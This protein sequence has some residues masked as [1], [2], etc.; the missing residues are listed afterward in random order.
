MI[1]KVLL[2]VILALSITGYAQIFT[3]GDISFKVN[4]S[5]PSTVQVWE[6][7]DA[8]GDLVIPRSISFKGVSY[9]VTS[10]GRSAFCGNKLIS[11]IIPASITSIEF[12]AFGSN[13]LTSI[14][15]PKSVKR[16]EDYA[17]SS[18]NM[19]NVTISK[20][21]TII[22][23]RAFSYNKLTTVNIPKSV[24]KIGPY[25]FDDN[26]LS[27]VIIRSKTPVLITAST[28]GDDIT[29]TT[30]NVPNGAVEAYKMTAV[31]KDFGIIE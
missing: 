29:T 31:W 2:I 17:F 15:I 27:T 13:N 7:P 9:I 6:S 23:Y 12:A 4:S 24:T 16:I 28:F 5:D 14:N 19:E 20:G 30:L 11:V 10:I 22:G 1:R 21:T 25:T 26:S 8:K 18:N 3:E